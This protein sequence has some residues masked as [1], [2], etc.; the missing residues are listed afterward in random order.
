MGGHARVGMAQQGAPAAA[1]GEQFVGREVLAAQHQHMVLEEQRVQLGEGIGARVARVEALDEH[2]EGRG[3]AA[4]VH[5][6]VTSR[7]AG[8]APVALLQGGNSI[9]VKMASGWRWLQC[10]PSRGLARTRRW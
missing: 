5:G 10:G 9:R 2:A 7:A 6:V 8:A 3:K 4:C 1:D